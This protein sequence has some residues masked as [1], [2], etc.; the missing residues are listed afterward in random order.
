MF[1]FVLMEDENVVG[2]YS[3]FDKAKEAQIK[4][5][6]DRIARVK[7]SFFYDPKDKN[8]QD[9]IDEFLQEIEKVKQS[10]N[11]RQFNENFD[12]GYSITVTELDK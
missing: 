2:S 12:W 7:N 9:I 5:C 11:P 6:N 1:I 10:E 4:R 3:T 8:D